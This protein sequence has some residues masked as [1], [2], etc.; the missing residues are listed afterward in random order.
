MKYLIIGNCAAGISAAEALRANDKT[1]EITIISSE[2]VPAYGRP[3]ISYFLSGKVKAENMLYREDSFYKSRK[4]EV[5]LNT[6]AQ[7]I[8]AAQKEVLTEDGRVLNYDKLLIASGSIP[9]VPPIKNLCGQKNVF[10]FLTYE[11]AK[12]IKESINEDSRV[13][14][15]GAGLIGLKAAEG[16]FGKVGKITVVDLADRVMASVLDKPSADIIQNHIARNDIEFI[17]N[18]SIAEIEG[19]NMA[20][21]VLLSDGQT[22]ECDILIIAVGVRPNIAV[23]KEAGLKINKGI[24]VD[25]YM[26]TSAAD[27][28]AAGDCVE[29]FDLIS[30][31]YKILALWPN[32][33]NQGE[34]AG[35][36]MAGLKQKSPAFFA[37]NAISFFGMQLISAGY[38]CENDYNY[39]FSDLTPQESKARRLNIQDDRL[40]GFLLINDFQRAGIYT[41][42]INN[43]T[44]LSELE[45]DIRAKD[46]GLGIYPENVRKGKI[47]GTP[48]EED[49]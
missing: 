11:D 20:G 24:V 43:K 28:Y 35:C 23:A 40:I 49:L 1:G 30:N 19:E 2:N 27:I 22:L 33:A 9:F 32:A 21:K 39:S 47:W 29:S 8:N 44:K 10:S 7:K 25:R 3:L 13:V 15:A 16:L 26:N 45:Y 17:L 38:I 46:I 5:L 37:M 42:L 31:E 14:I 41:D 36:N 4:I 48:K 6:K 34:I 12:R 18:T